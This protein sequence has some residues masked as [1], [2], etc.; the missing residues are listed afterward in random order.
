MVTEKRLDKSITRSVLGHTIASNLCWVIAGILLYQVKLLQKDLDFFWVC[1]SRISGG[2]LVFLW[3]LSTIRTRSSLIEMLRPTPSLILWGALG[4][5]S[6]FGFFYSVHQG[7]M[8]EASF[9]QSSQLIV[10]ATIGPIFL[11]EKRNRFEWILVCITCLGLFYMILG[12]ENANADFLNKNNL[13]AL[14]SGLTAAFAYAIVCRNKKNLAPIRY[15]LYW[16][17]LCS[18]GLILWYYFF[19]PSSTPTRAVIL[20]LLGTGVAGAGAQYF[21]NN[22]YQDGNSLFVTHLG[23]STPVIAAFA[24]WMIFSVEHSL[25]WY[26]SASLIFVSS[27]VFPLYREFLYS[28]KKIEVFE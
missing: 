23:F 2:A 26:I 20:C 28:P 16:T 25:Q 15:V 10:A 4:A 24:E 6:V 14:F 18:V 13:P 5:L 21:I 8:A 9:L 3:F 22:A 17:L 1:F 12:Q 19:P 7:S 11:N 27:S